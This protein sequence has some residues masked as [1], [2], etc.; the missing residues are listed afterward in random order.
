ME[1]SARLVSHSQGPCWVGEMCSTWQPLTGP[2]GCWSKCPLEMRIQSES[3]V[4]PLGSCPV[5]NEWEDRTLFLCMQCVR[6]H[7]FLGVIKCPFIKGGA[8]LMH[9]AVLSCRRE[10][11]LKPI[12]QFFHCL[13]VTMKTNMLVF[14]CI[15]L[16]SCEEVQFCRFVVCTL[17]CFLKRKS[18]LLGNKMFQSWS[19][20]FFFATTTKV[21]PMIHQLPHQVWRQIELGYETKPS[22]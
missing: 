12:L 18:S 22:I 1:P 21:K 10:A 20:F 14:G 15:S 13:F 11:N 7:Y 17:L 8:K 19:H 3:L 4:Y 2:Q 6:H 16:Q 9:F 5:H